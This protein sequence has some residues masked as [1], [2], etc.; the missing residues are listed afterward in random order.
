MR[1]ALLL[2]RGVV[3]ISLFLLSGAFAQAQSVDER[4][5]V[6][7]AL[8]LSY[9][10]PSQGKDPRFTVTENHVL[11]PTF[12]EEGVLIEISIEPKPSQIGSK[13][14]MMPKGEYDSLLANLG[15]IKS[16]GPYEE[17]P[18]ALF[19]SGWRDHGTIRYQ[20]AFIE[21]SERLGEGEPKPIESIRIYYLHPVT[22]VPKIGRDEKPDEVDHQLVCV[23]SKNYI[24]PETEFV[25][26]WSKPRERQ[27]VELGGPVAEYCSEDQE[28]LDKA[29]DAIGRQRF[30]IAHLT[31]QTLLNTYPN[32]E[33][34]AKAKELLS[35]PK[36]ARC[37]EKSFSNCGA[38]GPA[39]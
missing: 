39:R 21:T 36:I 37:G 18:D 30:D 3:I 1:K 13:P 9:G 14:A 34:A 8:T 11:V 28:L 27:T 10:Q 2:S 25:K 19:R 22:G 24:A 20:N 17:G 23:D 33:Y 4:D 15:S 5:I 12:S 32:S 26:L 35:D 29:I 7:H 16:I 6:L 38:D 31:L